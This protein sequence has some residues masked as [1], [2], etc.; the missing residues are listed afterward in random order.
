[1]GPAI[2]LDQMFSMRLLYRSP[3]KNLYV[4]GQG[5]H[6]VAGA[7]GVPGYNAAKIIS[8][9]LERESVRLG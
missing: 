2:T 8:E 5:T 9:D 4:T 6:P 3:I 7:I 1:M